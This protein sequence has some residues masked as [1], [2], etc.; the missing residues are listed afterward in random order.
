MRVGGELSD[1]L[2]VTSGVPRQCTRTI[3]VSHIYQ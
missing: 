1:S 3:V 2:P